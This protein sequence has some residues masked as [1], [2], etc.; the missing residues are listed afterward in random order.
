MSCGLSGSCSSTM[1]SPTRH[2]GMIHLAIAAVGV[3]VALAR[4][5]TEEVRGSLAP[6]ARSATLEPRAD[7][8]EEHTTADDRDRKT[9]QAETEPLKICHVGDLH[10]IVAGEQ[11]LPR[12]GPGLPTHGEPTRAAF[13]PQRLGN[14]ATTATS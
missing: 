4:D 1:S 6:A 14:S 7:E 10:S 5:L 12:G 2:R 3:M 11:S 13:R 9:D 8:P